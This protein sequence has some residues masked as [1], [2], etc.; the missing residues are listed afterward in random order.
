[1]HPEDLRGAVEHHGQE[2]RHMLGSR[3]RGHM[4]WNRPSMGMGALRFYW[5]KNLVTSKYTAH[6][7]SIGHKLFD[8]AFLP[9][10]LYLCAM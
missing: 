4:P 10:M 6:P 2:E 3:P 8:D 7:D 1:M 9:W 5:F